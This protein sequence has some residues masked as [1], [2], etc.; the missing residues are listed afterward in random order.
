ME[1]QKL[2]QWEPFI[3]DDLQVE[4]VMLDPWVRVPLTNKKGSATYEAEFYA[5]TKEG[6]YQFK[7]IYKRPGYNFLTLAE[8]VT[9]RPYKHDEY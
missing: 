6:I 5:P 4:F 8:R 3:T 7:V 2:N 1:N 9:V